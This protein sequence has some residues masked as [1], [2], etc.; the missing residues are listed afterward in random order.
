MRH[1]INHT[2]LFFLIFEV[3]VLQLNA[4]GKSAIDAPSG[5]ANNLAAELTHDLPANVETKPDTVLRIPTLWFDKAIMLEKAVH[6]PLL[7]SDAIVFDT[8]FKH[9]TR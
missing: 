7:N 8:Y 1:W 3:W 6:V 9:V 4:K 2:Q 5:L